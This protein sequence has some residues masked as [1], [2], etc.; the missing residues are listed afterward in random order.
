MN[1]HIYV[2]VPNLKNAPELS[3]DL[4][5]VPEYDHI[6]LSKLHQYE[7][8][9]LNIGSHVYHFLLGKIINRDKPTYC[10]WCS[11]PVRLIELKDE[12]TMPP[13]D[14]TRKFYG[15]DNCGARGPVLNY[16]S[17]YVRF[18]IDLA[19]AMVKNRYETRRDWFDDFK[20][21]YEDQ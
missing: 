14:L 6:S 19:D 9:K 11:Y 12:N 20:N 1:K 3:D 21:P 4:I 5:P 7:F 18:E 16:R 10:A 2:N 17:D 13:H 8:G 15:C